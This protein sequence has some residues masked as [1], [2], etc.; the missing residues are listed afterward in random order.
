M[1]ALVTNAGSF[2]PTALLAGHALKPDNMLN[3]PPLVSS[4][5]GLFRFSA[6]V[7]ATD[8]S[9]HSLVLVIPA[10]ESSGHCPKLTLTESP[11]ARA[12]WALD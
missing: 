12:W 10:M 3:H 8:S 7:L 4:R 1:W 5:T 2:M 6:F 9:Y 11:L